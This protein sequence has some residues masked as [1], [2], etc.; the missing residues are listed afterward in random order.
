VQPDATYELPLEHRT[1]RAQFDQLGLRHPETG[2]LLSH[3]WHTF[4]AAHF[5]LLVPVRV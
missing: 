5:Q 1:L 2:A 3:D 4:P